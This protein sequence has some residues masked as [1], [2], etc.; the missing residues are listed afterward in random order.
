MNLYEKK[1]YEKKTKLERGKTSQISIQ[2]SHRMNMT[3]KKRKKW[4]SNYSATAS[5]YSPSPLCNQKRNLISHGNQLLS[6]NM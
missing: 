6:P 5:L 2:L 4:N 3:E 1:K